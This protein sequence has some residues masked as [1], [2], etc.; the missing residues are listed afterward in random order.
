MTLT[1]VTPRFNLAVLWAM[2]RE[3]HYSV[4]GNKDVVVQTHCHEKYQIT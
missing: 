2:S 4:S 3:A 1:S